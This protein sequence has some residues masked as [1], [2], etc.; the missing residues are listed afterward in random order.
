[1][2]DYNLSPG[3]H[4]GS[5][6]ILSPGH[7]S[8]EEGEEEEEE[9]NIVSEEGKD[10]LAAL[11]EEEDD[12][13]ARAKK[14]TTTTTPTTSTATV[15]LAATKKHKR[16]AVLN[17]QPSLEVDSDGKF[18][19]NVGGSKSRVFFPIFSK[20]QKTVHLVRHG[21]STYNEAIFRSGQLGRTEDF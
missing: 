15:A 4:G 3:E 1:M 13:D 6:Y 8:E 11:R 19:S 14:T 9:V 12:I 17:N 2:G 10:F 21:Q 5:Q 7:E 18:V 20:G 16:M